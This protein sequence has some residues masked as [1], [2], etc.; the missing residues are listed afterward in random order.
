MRDDARGAC[1]ASA[2]RDAI[3]EYEKVYPFG[4]LGLLSDTPPVSEELI[5][6]NSPRGFSLCSQRSLE[7]SR[8]YLQCTLAERVEE[9]PD[10]RFWAELARRLDP[11]AATAAP[12]PG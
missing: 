5:Y 11:R 1:R 3:T 12:R 8:Y 7:R 6:I 4:W 9:W 10:E 2:P